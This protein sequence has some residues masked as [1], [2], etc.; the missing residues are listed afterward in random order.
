[1][2]LPH[3]LDVTQLQCLFEFIRMWHWGKVC[4][5]WLLCFVRWN[6]WI[7]LMVWWVIVDIFCLGPECIW[8]KEED[9]S[10]NS[11]K[12]AAEVNILSAT[13]SIIE[14][15]P[16][17]YVYWTG[18]YCIALVLWRCWLVVAKA[19]HVIINFCSN[20]LKIWGMK[21]ILVHY[22]V[23]VLAWYLISSKIQFWPDSKNAIWC[24]P[25]WLCW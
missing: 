7:L 4:H 5:L 13:S 21:C 12:C 9:K 19:R 1:V 16:A 18:L 15:M 6:E 20:S 11:G 2:A 8:F 14:W 10:G 23:P 25:K 3:L 22:P 24:I 17:V